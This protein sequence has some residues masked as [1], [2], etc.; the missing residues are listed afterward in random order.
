MIIVII[1]I[2][3]VFVKFLYVHSFPQLTDPTPF[4]SSYLDLATLYHL[5]F[6]LSTAS[7]AF[8]LRDVASAAFACPSWVPF[9][10]PFN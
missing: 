6:F 2:A 8:I 10:N 4:F 9:H 7:N 3:V 5:Y 1:I